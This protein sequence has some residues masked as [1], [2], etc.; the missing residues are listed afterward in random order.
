ME[1]PAVGHSDIRPANFTTLPHFSVSSAMSL[2]KS[3]GEPGSAMA[4]KSASRAMNLGYAL[5]RLDVGHESAC[6]PIAT[7][8]RTCRDRELRATLGQPIPG[9]LEIGAATLPFR[10]RLLPVLPR[11]VRIEMDAHNR[12]QPA[13]HRREDRA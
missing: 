7:I 10:E 6:P 13:S 12:G 2:P 3:A 9:T 8:E 4:P 11:L 5:D 1:C